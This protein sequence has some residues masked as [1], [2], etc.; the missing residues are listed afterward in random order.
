MACVLPLA[1][2]ER[3]WKEPSRHQSTDLGGEALVGWQENTQDNPGHWP[4]RGRVGGRWA[5]HRW[6]GMGGGRWSLSSSLQQLREPGVIDSEGRDG[7]GR[8]EGW[9]RTKKS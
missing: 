7:E 4:C 8:G 1:K 6:D 5:A 2:S 3:S 9:R